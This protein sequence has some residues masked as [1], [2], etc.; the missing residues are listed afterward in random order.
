[1]V[2]ATKVR[3][4]W[5]DQQTILEIALTK[6]EELRE[7]LLDVARNGVEMHKMR[8]VPAEHKKP[9]DPETTSPCEGTQSM[10]QDDS[11]DDV[12]PGEDQNLP[13][14]HRLERNST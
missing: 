13:K 5:L 3:H 4:G 14:Q 6:K 10:R 9:N 2:R 8:V 1:M 12:R 11:M 7:R